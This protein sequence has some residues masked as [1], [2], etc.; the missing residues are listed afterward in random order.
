MNP[1]RK[2]RGGLSRRRLLLEPL[3]AR[4]LLAMMRDDVPS[5]VYE[6]YAQD[7]MFEPVGWFG[8]YDLTGTLVTK[9]S[10][11]LIDPHWVLLTGHQ[12]YEHS[13]S[14]LRFGLGPNILTDPGETRTVATTI[15]YP[16]YAGGWGGSLNDIAL[17]Y[18]EDPILDV[19]PADRFRGTDEA[20]THVSIVGYGRP[21]TAT[22]GLGDYDGEKRG[23][24]NIVDSIGDGVYGFGTNYYLAEFGPLVLFPSPSLP[25]EFGVTPGDSGGGWFNDSGELVAL[26]AFQYAD[27][28]YSGGIRITQ[29]N[30]WIDETI[31]SQDPL[32]VSISRDAIQAPLTNDAPVLFT[33]VF[34]DQVA[35][36]DASDVIASG[37][38]GTLVPTVTPVGTGGTV[39]TISV[40][41][42][43]GDGQ[44]VVSIPADAA[45]NAGGNGNSASTALDAGVTYDVTPP[46]VAVIDVLTNDATPVIFGTATDANDV[47]TVTLAV[48]GQTF[49]AAPDADGN[50]SVEVPSA[51]SDGVNTVTVTVLDCAG[52]TSTDTATVTVDTVAPVVA[53]AD[54]VTNDDTPQLAGTVTDVSP[55][56]GITSV[57]VTV[58]GTQYPA[59]VSGTSWSLV[60]PTALAD[61]THTVTVT[62]ADA[63]GNTST[64]TATVTVDTAA[65]VVGVNSLTTVNKTP[66]LTGPITDASP[67]SGITGVTVVVGGQTLAATVSGNTWSAV[68]SAPLAVGTYNVTATAVDAAGNTAADG[69]AN[70]LVV[71]THPWHNSADPCN[72]D[73]RS[74]VEPVDVLLVINYINAHGSGPLPAPGPNTPPPY[75][76]VNAD[77]EV[78]PVDVLLV[79]NWINSQT[80]GGAGEAEPWSDG[81]A[82]FL[83]TPTL[84]P[85]SDRATPAT[86]GLLNH[87]EQ[88]VEGIGGVRSPAPS[89]V[90]HSL[91]AG[92]S[93]AGFSCRDW[94]EAI[95]GEWSRAS[96][97]LDAILND[98][99]P[100]QGGRLPSRAWDS[101]QTPCA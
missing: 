68:V 76:D 88:A 53:A 84:W 31:A 42:M 37:A 74:G 49:A 41:G 28:A 4:L 38:P 55:S 87:G 40:S 51:L 75:V 65:P 8:T 35:D 5:S 48:A 46:G 83:A 59:A 80:A 100:G 78:A 67:S 63:A 36:F 44:V 57:L 20:G 86:A 73:G 45:H 93:D 7:P 13:Y 10:A 21:G 23:G 1:K 64:D 33:A 29:Y 89:A 56:T 101:G 14:E 92:E 18:I 26:S 15:I 81:A 30:S 50:W 22:A 58:G 3:E 97:L 16:D 69:T 34:S 52:N 77:N 6:A 98:I 95:S 66:T 90:G 61:G 91:A 79:I 60:L 17:G 71:N 11:V 47:A 85:V 25:L 96:V 70:E 43:T 27:Y 19:T 39:Y 2:R 99:V 54:L 62:A 9:G 82:G 32:E 12:L 72:V 24:E 94:D